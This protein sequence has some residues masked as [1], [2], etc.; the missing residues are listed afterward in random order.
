MGRV[1]ARVLGVGETEVTDR[2]RAVMPSQSG[3]DFEIVSASSISFVKRGRKSIADPALID[4]LKKLS[5][6]QAMVIRK[7][8]QDPTSTTYAND[9][10]RVASQIRTA[11]KNAQLTGFSIVWSPDG[12]P[13]VKL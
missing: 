6:G 5:K 3:G 9:K 4:Q 11:C 13:Q 10:A 1:G 12:V 7:Y 8:K 2:K